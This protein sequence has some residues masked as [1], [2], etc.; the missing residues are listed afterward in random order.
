[1]V[2]TGKTLCTSVHPIHVWDSMKQQ[3]HTTASTTPNNPIFKS[4]LPRTCWNHPLGIW[5]IAPSSTN[6]LTV[7]NTDSAFVLRGD[8]EILWIPGKP[9]KHQGGGHPKHPLT[10]VQT[11]PQTHAYKTSITMKMNI[12]GLILFP[13]S[14]YK[15]SVLKMP[16]VS[17]FHVSLKWSHVLCDYKQLKNRH[18]C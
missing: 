2:N 7:S 15:F 10:H 18:L 8:R 9:S 11:H 12:S 14:T 16:I 17:V 3:P 4:K 13:T 1:M 6:S 5:T